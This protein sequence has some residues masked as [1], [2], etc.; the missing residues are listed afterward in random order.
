MKLR[1]VGAFARRAARVDVFDTDS[2]SL[3]FH[4]PRALVL[5]DEQVLVG[6][7]KMDDP[8]GHGR[9]M[10]NGSAAP[11]R[12]R[13]GSRDAADAVLANPF[14]FVLLA[15]A[16]ASI[17][18]T[19]ARIACVVDEKPGPKRHGA[20]IVPTL[21]PRLSGAAR[22][23]HSNVNSIG[24]AKACRRKRPWAPNGEG[25]LN[26]SDR[27]LGLHLWGY[28]RGTQLSFARHA[29]PSSRRPR[30]RSTSRHGRFKTTQTRQ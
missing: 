16:L 24:S 23:I 5:Y 18:R 1:F 28:L 17:P 6:L 15:A 3:V 11:G 14:D 4:Q 10:G 8:A 20:F 2:E 13:C 25:A 19:F 22:S 21:S 30:S 26:E 29:E 27:A 7:C 12:R 9:L